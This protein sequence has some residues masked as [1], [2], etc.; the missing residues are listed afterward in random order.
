MILFA[1]MAILT[2]VIGIIN[3]KVDKCCIIGFVSTCILL[4][5]FSSLSGASLYGLSSLLLPSSFSQSDVSGTHYLTPIIAMTE[6]MLEK[7]C[8]GGYKN[9]RFQ[10]FIDTIDQADFEMRNQPSKYM[11]TKMCPCDPALN[12]TA[13]ASVSQST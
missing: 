1:C 12:I 2:V 10:F 6:T 8:D 9:S 11:C 3:A 4:I 5:T 13:W 7:Y